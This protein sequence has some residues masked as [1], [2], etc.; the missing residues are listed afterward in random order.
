MRRKAKFRMGST[1]GSMLSGLV[2]IPCCA[3]NGGDLQSCGGRSRLVVLLPIFLAS[4]THV[5]LAES[6]IDVI[7]R[8]N[9]QFAAGKYA[10]ALETYKQLAQNDSVAP[11]A[12]L[13]H[14]MAA[15]H[16]KLGHISEARELWVRAAAL[17]DERFEAQTRYNLGNCNYAEALKAV[18]AQ[19]VKKARQLLD[20]AVGQYR[21]AIHLNPNLANAR[22]NLE[23]AE[24][25]KQ[26]IDKQSTT[27]PQSQK[28]SQPSSGE[29]QS[30]P[31]SQQQ[32]S[33]DQ[34]DQSQQSSQPSSQESQP[35]SQP[36]SQ[37]QEEPQS[38]P[39]S[40][41]EPQPQSQPADAQSQPSDEKEGEQKMQELHM[42]KEEAER[43]L[44]KIRDAER[45]RRMELM[46]REA[47]K[48]KAVDRDW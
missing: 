18:E 2:R 42:T 46:R 14:D 13:L 44:Q 9:D 48:Y 41:P 24:K 37:Q 15:A 27:Q 33:S 5:C 11:S 16:F 34:S 30:Q 40:Q 19:D 36:S 35:Q 31:S 38:Q 7:K 28:S 43:L 26:E 39:A 23:L 25:L 4:I 10:D 17:K 47:A 20:K 45:A 3:R 29:S 32:S 6:D 22:A 21:D 1:E 8:G 12:E